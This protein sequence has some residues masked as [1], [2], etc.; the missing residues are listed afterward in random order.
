MVL[1]NLVEK[2]LI[3]TT[4][5]TTAWHHGVRDA[6]PFAVIED[7]HPGL[8]GEWGLQITRQT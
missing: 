8:G 6:H 5:W 4:K 1:L 3:S 2:R 7:I